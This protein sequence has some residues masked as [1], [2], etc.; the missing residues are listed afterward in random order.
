MLSG[1]PFSVYVIPRPLANNT[2]VELQN[3][4]GTVSCKTAFYFAHRIDIRG[5]RSSRMLRGLGI[6]SM[7]VNFLVPPLQTAVYVSLQ[8][9]DTQSYTVLLHIGIWTS[10]LTTA[11]NA[12]WRRTYEEKGWWW[13]AAEM[14]GNRLFRRSELNLYIHTKWQ[15]HVLLLSNW[16]TYRKHQQYVKLGWKATG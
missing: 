9:I 16:P 10:S 5:L 12:T 13:E 7:K 2:Q 3:L 15:S 6:C 1:G 14:R 8:S 11:L 4:G